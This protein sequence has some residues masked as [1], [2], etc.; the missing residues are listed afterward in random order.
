MADV[1]DLRPLSPEE[2]EVLA[3]FVEMG[4][5]AHY[6]DVVEALEPAP[7]PSAD[8]SADDYRRWAA[9]LRRRGSLVNACADLLERRLL[10]I[11]T[12]E[13]CGIT[14]TARTLLG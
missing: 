8:P 2:R 1:I 12:G 6:E 5:S 10:F 13:V 9:Q 4:G 11:V 7:E 14:D 3:K